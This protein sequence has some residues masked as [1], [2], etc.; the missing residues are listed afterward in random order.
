MGTGYSL[1]E[2]AN[3]QNKQLALP[4]E[5]EYIATTSRMQDTVGIW[6]IFNVLWQRKWLI[7]AIVTS[8]TVVAGIVLFRV[9]PTFRAQSLLIIQAR[10]PDI[11]SLANVAAGL[12]ADPE[13]IQ[14]EMVVLRSPGLA[15]E[16]IDR[17]GL[18]QDPE[19]NA[20][21][22]PPGW[23]E[24]T[25]SQYL[26]PVA[27]W[28]GTTLGLDSRSAESQVHGSAKSAAASDKRHVGA[29]RGDV[30]SAF[31]DKLEVSVQGNSRVLAVA[32]SSHSAQTAAQVP[33][34]LAEVYLQR[35]RDAKQKIAELDTELLS[36]RVAAL[37]QK[38]QSADQA[39]ETYR[40]KSGLLQG[41]KGSPLIMQQ[42]TDTST[43]LTLAQA[44]SSQ[45]QTRLD[46]IEALARTPGGI[47]SSSDVMNS[48][49]IPY[50]RE[51]KIQ[52]QRKKGELSA[53]LTDQHPAVLRLQAGIQE[54]NARIKAEEKRVV[55]GYRSD[56]AATKANEKSVQNAFDQFKTGVADANE[57]EIKLRSLQRDA[58]ADRT[59]LATMLSRLKETQQQEGMKSQQADARIV[60]LADV[61]NTPDFPKKGAMMALA[62]VG[63]LLLSVLIVL[64]SEQR[65]RG[66]RSN[67]QIEQALS[68]PVLGAVPK[69]GALSN[70]RKGSNTYKL[71][72]QSDAAL[73]E[74]MRSI[75]GSIVLSHR[76]RSPRK[77][78]I[79]SS[80]PNEGKTAI[81][82]NMAR[83][84][85]LAGKNVVVVDADLRSPD[86]HHAFASPKVPGLV[87]LVTG[88]AS[89]DTVLRKD[90][91]SGAWFI[92][93]G[94]AAS[95][96]L[97]ILTS[98]RLD[99]I[100]DRLTERFDLV[101]FDSPP[102]NMFVDA[103]ILSTKIEETLF[104]VRWGGTPQE[105]V[106]DVF[107]RHAQ[108]GAHV[109]GVIFSM[110]SR[111]TYSQYG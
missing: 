46:Q 25:F 98:Q 68:M 91:T 55:E 99:E 58:D 31:L 106:R 93:A 110:T 5:L 14:S 29:Q 9:Q 94:T 51:Q 6:D 20:A 102:S 61:P 95:D 33:N 83:V 71:F 35:Q 8:I 70:L 73:K 21:L 97:A 39:V 67:K 45:A 41:D 49:L 100:L 50:L 96:P 92:T 40:K 65:D 81:A 54:M 42:L 74:A 90:S 24:A 105:I 109:S 60:S 64:V 10:S 37:R 52:L 82:V 22:R 12:P 47:E 84:E 38:V 88:D 72:D 101:I 15:K 11:A 48:A 19:F 63:S 111:R 4:A 78:L 36:K 7:V 18:A 85:A 43:Q 53:K 62:L 80:V 87:E 103:R 28:L 30:I 34:T 44:A 23:L 26:R 86:I 27:A 3:K 16:A 59:L 107:K 1:A 17:L 57:K 2:Q 66:F 79:T 69:L 77:L 89:I 32:F 13:S 104:V 76:D 75:Y 108:S 56:V